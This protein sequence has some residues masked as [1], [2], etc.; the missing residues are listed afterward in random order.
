[1]FGQCKGILL[2]R[3]YETQEARH[4][5]KRNMQGKA[6][7]QPGKIPEEPATFSLNSEEY[8]FNHVIIRHF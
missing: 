4:K 1:M 5:W 7:D 8:D 2:K 3:H 6:L